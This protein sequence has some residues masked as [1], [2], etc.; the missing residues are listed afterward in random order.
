MD[1]QSSIKKRVLLIYVRH[2]ER[3]DEVK[4][5]PPIPLEKF[6]DPHLTDNGK[7][8]AFEVGKSVIAPFLLAKGFAECSIKYICSPFLRVLQ[9]AP[10]IIEGLK[11]S[12][13]IKSE[14]KTLIV[15][16]GLGTRLLKSFNMNPIEELTVYS[17]E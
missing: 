14:H 8:M 17:V 6:F 4:C 3:A 10:H 7:T 9:T 13:L 1:K 11:S 15:N 5:D 16:N 2:G 12:T